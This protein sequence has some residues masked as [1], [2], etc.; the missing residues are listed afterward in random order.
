LGVPL[1]P[2]RRIVSGEACTGADLGRSM[3]GNFRRRR[4]STG[5]GP[6][7]DVADPGTDFSGRSGS[8]ERILMKLNSFEK[9][10]T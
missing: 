9:T 4:R 7:P 2:D 3:S 8:L 10:N 1:W 6:T 5:V